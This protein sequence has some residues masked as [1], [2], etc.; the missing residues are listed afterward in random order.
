MLQGTDGKMCVTKQVDLAQAISQHLEQ[1]YP[2]AHP[3]DLQPDLKVLSGL[4]SS[5][6]AVTF[7]SSSSK[8]EV[9]PSIVQSMLQCVPIESLHLESDLSKA[10]DHS[11]SKRA[12]TMLSWCSWAASFR[13]M[14]GLYSPNMGGNVET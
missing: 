3:A 13:L 9:H 4:R 5:G 2:D 12:D 11:K 1:A 7:N 8:R 6:S 14:C 10:S